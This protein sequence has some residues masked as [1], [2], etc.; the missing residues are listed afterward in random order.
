MQTQV[1]QISKLLLALLGASSLAAAQSPAPAANPAAAGPS[2]SASDQI[3][4]P[5]GFGDAYSLD[6][7][8]LGGQALSEQQQVDRWQAELAAGRARAGTLSGAYFSYR[9]H[10]HG[11]RCDALVKGDEPA[12]TRR[13]GCSRNSPRMTPV[14]RSIAPRASAG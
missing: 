6:E 5:K 2:F 10:A 14:V 12:V 9:A 8:R 7:I 13:P 11:L 4:N 3:P 1:T